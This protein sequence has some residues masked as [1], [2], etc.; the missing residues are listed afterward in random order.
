MNSF[1]KW[2]IDRYF[3]ALAAVETCKAEIY[4]SIKRLPSSEMEEAVEY[5]Q[6]KLLQFQRM[7]SLANNF[8]DTV[9]DQ[10]L[11]LKF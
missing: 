7:D 1:A 11:R 9:L 5:F 4:D 3:E 6:Q 10:F 2:K 8:R